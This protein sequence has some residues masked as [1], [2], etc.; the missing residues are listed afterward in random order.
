MGRK[1]DKVVYVVMA[2]VSLCL[3]GA[4]CIEDNAVLSRR[5]AV[6]CYDTASGVVCVDAPGVAP[7]APTDAD[8]DGVDDSFLC[9]AEDEA[10]SPAGTADPG[11]VDDGVADEADDRDDD[12]AEGADEA[13]DEADDDEADD[14]DDA[15]GADEADDEADE[16]APAPDGTPVADDALPRCGPDGLPAPV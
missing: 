16:E 5:A 12:D 1:V 4:G 10:A 14:V 8:G 15:E 7:G 11:A 2:A 9:V 13:D 6:S 3:L